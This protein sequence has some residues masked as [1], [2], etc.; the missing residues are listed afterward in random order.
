MTT[1]HRVGWGVSKWTVRGYM[2]FCCNHFQ[3]HPKIK[4]Q[5]N[6][7]CENLIKATKN[8]PQVMAVRPS[9]RL[10]VRPFPY[11]WDIFIYICANTRGISINK[12]DTSE[13][14]S[15]ISAPTRSTINWV[16][17]TWVCHTD[18]DDSFFLLHNTISFRFSCA[19]SYWLTWLRTTHG[20]S[21]MKQP[22]CS[23]I[24]LVDFNFSSKQFIKI[25][26]HFYF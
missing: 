10:L 9:V 19:F 6:I 18:D 1:W 15:S 11:E 7:K 17:W 24:F 5:V 20:S 14:V 13:L 4:Q 22:A 21:G 26:E 12:T 25:M 3:F 23:Y 2:T 8:G 16:I